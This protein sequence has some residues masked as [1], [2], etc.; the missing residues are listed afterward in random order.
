VVTRQSLRDEILS[1][2]ERYPGVHPRE[3]ERQ[4]GLANRLASYHLEA[5]TKEGVLARM[6]EGGYARYFPHDALR[7]SPRSLSFVCLMRR[8][9]A[10]QITL[11]LLSEGELTPGAMSGSLG[12]ARPS[13]SYHLKALLEEEILAVREEGRERRYTLRDAEF[14]KRSLASFHPL[15]GD[16][17]AFSALWDDLVGR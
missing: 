2:V 8:P 7:L 10:L 4:M 16:L 6:D 3:V 11:L 17:D 15:P 5:L 12:L 1:F 14:V 9:P 13:V